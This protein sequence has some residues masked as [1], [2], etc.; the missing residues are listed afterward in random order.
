VPLPAIIGT[1]PADGAENAYP[2]GGFTLYFASPMNR[3]TLRD[4]VTIEPEPWR[5]FDDYYYEWDNSYNLSFPTEPSTTYT[6][7]I[8]Q[9]MEDIYGNAIETERVFTYTT[10]A[11][12]PNISLQTP[13]NVGFYNAYN[14]E[15]QLFLTHR[16]VSQVDL[17]LYTV[18]TQDF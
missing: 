15:T 4:R 16:N 3:E 1:D 7:T 17:T 10:A 2:Y 9:G 5:D 18:N 12:D 11:Y 13:G 14:A 6:I 8:A